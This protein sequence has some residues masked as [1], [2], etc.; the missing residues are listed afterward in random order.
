M[1]GIRTNE[2][3]NRYRTIT[4]FTK[5]CYR[6]RQWSTRITKHLYNFYPLYDWIVKDIWI[7]NGSLGMTTM[8]RV[9]GNDY[10]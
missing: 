8:Q 5:A 4:N 3:Y 9:E 6:R 2:S 10:I 1:V 7:A